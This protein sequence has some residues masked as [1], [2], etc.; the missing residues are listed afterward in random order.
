MGFRRGSRDVQ[1][2]QHG[3]C[4]NEIVA[5]PVWV[6][7]E[8]SCNTRHHIQDLGT[9]WRSHSNH[10]ERTER[11]CNVECTSE[12]FDLLAE[13]TVRGQYCVDHDHKVVG[14]LGSDKHSVELKRHSRH[15]DR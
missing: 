11:P 13:A 10:T 2:Q 15:G 9:W 4:V 8:H 7:H 3:Q 12:S 14:P 5:A 1:R 6:D